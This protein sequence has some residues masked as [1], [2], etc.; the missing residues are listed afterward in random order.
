M[1]RKHLVGGEVRQGLVDGDI[2]AGDRRVLLNNRAA[3][4]PRPSMDKYS[5]DLKRRHH[6]LRLLVHPPQVGRQN[7][8]LRSVDRVHMSP[9]HGRDLLTLKVQRHVAPAREILE[10][11]LELIA[12]T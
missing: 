3:R 2:D 7:Y 6:L 10:R 12:G 8:G 5:V 9:K 1:I 11:D 4:L